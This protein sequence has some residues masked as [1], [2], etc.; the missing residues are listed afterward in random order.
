MKKAAVWIVVTVATLSLIGAAEARAP[1][2][3]T[4]V[5]YGLVPVGDGPVSKGIAFG[6]VFSGRVACERRRKFELVVKSGDGSA[7]AD[8]GK[9]SGEGAIAALVTEKEL[10]GAEDAILV[11]AKTK[12]CAR[13]R[14]SLTAT[15][16]SPRHGM[17]RA[18]PAESAVEILTV[19]GRDEDGAFTGIVAAGRR[20]CV[21]RRKVELHGDDV[22]LDRGTTTRDGAWAL[23]LTEDEF[24]AAA[25]FRVAVKR[26][27]ECSGGRD[28]FVPTE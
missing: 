23:H 20:E 2:P 18:R 11:V 26:T 10:A 9:S 17:A 21:G 16:S 8:A 5:L 12:R 7:T 28:R 3:G 13:V 25:R 1:A 22:R 19:N 14:L 24:N 6:K 4:I 27:A 15:A